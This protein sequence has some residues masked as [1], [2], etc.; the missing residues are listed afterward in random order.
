MFSANYGCFLLGT[1]SN[2]SCA[3]RNQRTYPP[4]QR[5]PD[6]KPASLSK[7]FEL[8]LEDRGIPNNYQQISFESTN[9]PKSNPFSHSRVPSNY[10]LY[11]NYW[12][13]Y[14]TEKFKRHRCRSGLLIWVPLG[15]WAHRF[16]GA[17]TTFST[18]F[19]VKN[20]PGIRQLNCRKK[21][22]R[23]ESNQGSARNS[24]R[25]KNRRRAT[26]THNTNLD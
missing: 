24:L 10:T 13:R 19:R 16:R 18:A 17:H 7:R 12:K 3:S 25:T 26:P 8:L 9:P 11:E 23:T 6:E 1:R 20:I 14:Y 4:S 15:R 22:D 5:Y 2:G 21:T